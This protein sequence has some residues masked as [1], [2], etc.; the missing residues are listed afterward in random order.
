[1]RR[2]AKTDRNHAEIMRAL[3]DIG[4]TVQDL[5]AVGEGCPDLL[6][7]YAGRNTLLEVKDGNKP[8]SH[9]KLT[10]RQVYWHDCWRGQKAVVCSA[11]EAVYVAT[12]GR[13][14]L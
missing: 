7:G 4:A 8:P 9:R 1:M 10:P 3:L 5:S 13:V 14:S 2:A 12:A 11:E 6:V